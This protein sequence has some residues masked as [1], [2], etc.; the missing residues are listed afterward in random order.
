MLGIVA[1]TLLEYASRERQAAEN[2][3]QLALKQAAKQD[4]VPVDKVNAELDFDEGVWR[5]KKPR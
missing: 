2:R 5:T 1:K 4:G 3:W